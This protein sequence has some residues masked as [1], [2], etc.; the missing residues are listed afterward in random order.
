[1][2]QAEYAGQIIPGSPLLMEVFDP[3]KIQIEGARLGEVNCPM[4]IDSMY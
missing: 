4:V 3:N 2:L 1:M